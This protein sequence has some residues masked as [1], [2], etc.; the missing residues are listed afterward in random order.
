MQQIPL[1]AIIPKGFI[2]HIGKYETKLII[3]HQVGFACDP[4]PQ[5]CKYRVVFNRP[6]C[7]LSSR[8][9]KVDLYETL[10]NRCKFN[11]GSR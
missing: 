8:R 3:R 1:M 5:P 6:F 10:K 2:T 4:Y 9:F 7:K 11:D